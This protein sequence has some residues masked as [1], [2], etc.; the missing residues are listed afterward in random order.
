[1][2]DPRVKGSG[3]C[4]R[5]QMAAGCVVM[6]AALMACTDGLAPTPTAG[7]PRV[8]MIASSYAATDIP[9]EPVTRMVKYREKGGLDYALDEVE[10]MEDLAELAD[11]LG[12]DEDEDDEDYEGDEE[13]D[14]DYEGDEE[15][16]D[17]YDEYAEYDDDDDLELI[18]DGEWPDMRTVRRGK[19][20]LNIDAGFATFTDAKAG[21]GVKMP[22]R[23]WDLKGVAVGAGAYGVDFHLMDKNI[24]ARVDS[25][26]TDDVVSFDDPAE[27]KTRV[28]T[29]VARM[30]VEAE[31]SGAGIVSHSAKKGTCAG[32]TAMMVD[33]LLEGDVGI[34]AALLYKDGRKVSVRFFGKESFYADDMRKLLAE[35]C[36]DLKLGG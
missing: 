34:Y 25:L 26:E 10:D 35:T 19:F 27:A 16:D 28:G 13:D 6:S 33:I 15:D 17:D 32:A 1:M 11:D 36:K 2:R 7:G 20:D 24:L 12:L 3:V 14:D 4:A 5:M 8:E 21:L 30:K 31:K 23:Y 18:G 9:A 29:F 22:G